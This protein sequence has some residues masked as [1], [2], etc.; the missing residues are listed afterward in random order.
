[1]GFTYKDVFA[2]RTVK[3]GFY[4]GNY[5]IFTENLS[6][7]EFKTQTAV[8]AMIIPKHRL[9]KLL[10]KYDSIKQSMKEHCMRMHFHTNK[11][12]V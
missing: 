8:Q 7:F 10:R 3:R 6:E 2:H 5:N 1:M 9:L 12:M 11:A 4:F